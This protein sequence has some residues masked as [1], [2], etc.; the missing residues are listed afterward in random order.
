MPDSA[1]SVSGY[2]TSIPGDIPGLLRRGS[3]VLYTQALIPGVVLALIAEE[4]GEFSDPPILSIALFGQHVVEDRCVDIAWR[5]RRHLQLDLTDP[6][7]RAHA[8]WWVQFRIINTPDA[9]PEQVGMVRQ[10]AQ[11]IRCALSG[12]EMTP[13]QIDILARLVLR[14]AGRTP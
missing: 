12:L 3:P 14:L 2:L 8:A 1:T 4:L 5:D 7:G 11:I 13:I 6:T 9:L 10:C